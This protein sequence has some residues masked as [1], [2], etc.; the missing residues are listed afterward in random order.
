MSERGAIA[1]P[2]HPALIHG[3]RRVSYAELHGLVLRCVGALRSI[4]I[5]EGDRVG[6]LGLNSI[7]Y[8]VLMQAALRIG[9]VTVAINWRLV[10]REIAYIAADAELALL[11]T[12]AERL[13]QIGSGTVGRVMLVDAPHQDMP[14]FE[15]WVREHAPDPDVLAVGPDH[16]AIQLYTS[17][18]TGH[19]KGAILTHGN[20][21]AAIAQSR[22]I[23]ESWAE[24]DANDVSLIAMPQ[25]HI[26][27]TGWTV[28]TLNAGVTGVLLDR[29]EIGELI[30]AIERHR[31]TRMFAVPAVLG[32]IL[33]HPR[34]AD[35]DLNS[36]RCLLYGAS[37]IP[38]DVLKRSMAMFPNARF[39]QMYGATETCGTI[40]YLPPED[41][42]IEGTP[43]MAGCGKP[44]PEVE[45]RIVD[46]AGE[47]LPAG[48]IGEVLVR[49]PLVMSGYHKLADATV[50]AFVEGGWYRTGDAGYLDQDGYLYLYDR[51]RDMIVS[52]GENIYP[53]EVENVLHEHDAVRDCAVIAV[54]DPR[55][56]EAVKAIVVP[57]PGA[58]IDA[59]ALIA[60]A[61]E[62]IAGYKVPKS[63]DFVDE[64]PR[65][66]SGKILKRELRRPYWPLGERKIG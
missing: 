38:L 49:S 30:D 26:A 52:G 13:P 60:F 24:W 11:V 63:V 12:E 62:R 16:A 5:G 21:A 44:Y 37:P 61:R 42:R 65:N 10:A 51:V 17:G 6:Y 53:V 59:A 7:D 20:F 41:H 3:Q 57:E 18:T 8:A 40:V 27:G 35:A 32:M 28:S 33:D 19:P 14:A 34:A 46:A 25:F 47:A 22:L 36:V 4:G 29:P 66:P 64:L 9:A 45:L 39:V 1:T 58:A 43:R 55:W 23:G 56:G 2:D 15:I 31:V 48:A 54:P 50:S